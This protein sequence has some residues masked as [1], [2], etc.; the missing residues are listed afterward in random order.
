MTSLLSKYEQ[1][2]SNMINLERSYQNS[3]V[4]INASSFVQNI[5]GTNY[6]TSLII[7]QPGLY[8]LTQNI[9]FNP[10]Q[11]SHPTDSGDPDPVQFANGLDPM[12]FGIGFF[13]A[14]VIKAKD[15]IID[16]NGYSISHSEAHRLQQR[17]FSNIE[18]ANAAFIPK[19]G[20]HDFTNRLI[21]AKNVWIKNG[22]LGK[23]SH[24]G[25]HGNNNENILI[26]DIQFDDYEV[27]AC[28][29]NNVKGLYIDNCTARNST[30]IPVLGSFSASRFIRP[31]I[32]RLLSSSINIT[33]QLETT[34]SD[35]SSNNITIPSNII[36]NVRLN[37]EISVDG[38]ARG[39]VS[40]IN[41]VDSVVTINYIGGG[42]ALNI[43][44]IIVFKSTHTPQ[45]IW[46]DI[47]SEHLKVHN[48]IVVD[49]K[50]INEPTS[51][52]EKL[53]YLKSADGLIVPSNTSY[54]ANVSGVLDGNAYGFVVNGLG[55]AVNGFPKDMSSSSKDVLIQNV[56]V[57][58][59]HARIN[60]VKVHASPDGKLMNDPIGAVF[61]CIHFVNRKEGLEEEL[62]F[63]YVMNPIAIAQLLVA[64][65]IHQNFNFGSLSTKR[66]SI[67]PDIIEWAESN[68]KFGDGDH[69][70]NTLVNGD[71]MFHVNKG[72]VVFKMDALDTGYLRNCRVY[73]THNFG[74][75]GKLGS[76]EYNAR[77][78]KSH[79]LATYNGYGGANTRAFS[80]ASSHRVVLEN[81][82]VGNLISENGM[83]VGVDV[84][85]ASSDIQINGLI[86]REITSNDSDPRIS[87][88][89]DPTN[90]AVAIGVRETN[91]VINLTTQN[92]HIDMKYNDNKLNKYIPRFDIVR[93]DI[94]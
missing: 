18:L 19:Q 44:D 12:A 86:I 82:E 15:V 85:L 81:C 30:T 90:S 28:S 92:C 3:V 46:D 55:V 68:R 88:L 27:A 56:T 66:N 31:Y 57:S 80:L 22:Y 65:A 16:L 4:E 74:L 79:P 84:H 39:N 45:R 43:G 11:K 6:D 24:H 53:G 93:E 78:G 34:V 41:Y 42:N 2:K 48:H 26:T 72:V 33:T 14:I 63:S 62:K 37:D 51:T 29:L 76:D 91:T 10:N 9:T 71:S 54:Y 25:I 94:R 38:Q 8:K 49:K 89:Y 67:T 36:G 58:Q 23:S 5:N 87:D 7:D 50:N 77:I 52:G 40:N 1:L 69:S 60:E 83:A 20:P 13:A 21:P 35:V 75:K 61:Q 59:T 47:R 17:F 73:N 70:K 64:K 32:K